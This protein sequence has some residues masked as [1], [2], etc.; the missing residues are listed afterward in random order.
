MEY[1]NHWLIINGKVVRNWNESVLWKKVCA[2]E[3]KIAKLLQ[4]EMS[5][6]K[7]SFI[8][9]LYAESDKLWEGIRFEKAKTKEI[10]K[11]MLK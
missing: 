2:I 11:E 10:E 9:K 1:S 7:W 8:E 5:K 3:E 4:G 6:N